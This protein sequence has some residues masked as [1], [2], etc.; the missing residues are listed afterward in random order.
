MRRLEVIMSVH[1]AYQ[2]LLDIA[3]RGREFVDGEVFTPIV[4]DDDPRMSEVIGNG[5]DFVRTVLVDDVDET[6]EQIEGTFALRVLRLTRNEETTLFLRSRV[7]WR[8]SA[9]AMHESFA[10]Y[11]LT[12]SAVDEL[13]NMETASDSNADEID[14]DSMSEEEV[15]QAVVPMLMDVFS[16]EHRMRSYWCQTF[17]GSEGELFPAD[18]SEEEYSKIR[19]SVDAAFKYQERAITR[20]QER[21]YQLACMLSWMDMGTV[22]SEE[23]ISLLAWVSEQPEVSAVV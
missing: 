1:D 6:N 17:P 10:K 2:N 13:A 5:F 23:L 9:G 15:M 11:D 7:T 12:A 4:A 21:E 20:L 14:F 18:M 19:G 16:D 8:T 22:G 3:S